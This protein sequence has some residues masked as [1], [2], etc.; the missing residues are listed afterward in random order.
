MPLWS[1][2]D[3]AALALGD[4]APAGARDLALGQIA[5]SP[6]AEAAHA[7]RLVGVRTDDLVEHPRQQEGVENTVLVAVDDEPRDRVAPKDVAQ[8]GR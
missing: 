5:T 4:E 2:G 7:E 8:G 6:G 3:M 1:S